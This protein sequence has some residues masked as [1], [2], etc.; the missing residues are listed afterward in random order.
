MGRLEGGGELCLTCLLF[1]LPG[2][3]GSSRPSG[4][5]WHPGPGGTAGPSRSC[6]APWRGRRQGGRSPPAVRGHW[7]GVGPSAPL[8]PCCVLKQGCF[9]VLAVLQ[10]E[11]SQVWERIRPNLPAK[12]LAEIQLA[13]PEPVAG[14]LPSGAWPFQI[15]YLSHSLIKP[16]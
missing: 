4:S 6:R 1:L 12:P 10:F 9:V 15:N 13:F 11:Q 7:G 16:L 2:R 14:G 3:E 8:P 5:G